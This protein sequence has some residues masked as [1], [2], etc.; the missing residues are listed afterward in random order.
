MNG[1][2]VPLLS[3]EAREA[4]AEDDEHAHKSPWEIL[5][6]LAAQIAADEKLAEAFHERCVMRQRLDFGE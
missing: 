1:E 5:L 3:G 2:R 4:E 6:E